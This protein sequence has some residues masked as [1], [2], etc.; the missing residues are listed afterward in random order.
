MTTSDLS[1]IRD[2]FR[3]PMVADHVESKSK[4]GNNVKTFW[5]DCDSGFV[6]AA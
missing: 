6:Y 4:I 5:P 3:C 1:S 2:A